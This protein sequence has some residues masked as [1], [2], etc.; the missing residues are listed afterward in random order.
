[1]AKGGSGD[2]LTGIITSL[3]AQR[4]PSKE[5]CILGVYIHGLAGDIASKKMGLIS[6][7]PSDLIDCLAEAFEE[8]EKA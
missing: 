4:I 7:L 1:M 2:A 5:A 6:M 8:L 3:L